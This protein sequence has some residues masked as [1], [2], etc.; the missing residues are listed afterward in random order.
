MKDIGSIFPL[1]DS[2]FVG[3][4]AETRITNVGNTI[5]YSLC[6]ETFVVIAKHLDGTNR[7]VLLPAYTCDTIITPF[8]EQGWD[9]YYYPVDHKL[10]I[11]I[12]AVLALCSKLD[13]DLMVVHP[14]YGMD[15]SQKEI[16][17]LREVHSKGCKLVVDLTQCIFSKQRLDFAD[18]YV[19]SYR[20]WF[21][22][23]DGA[24]LE[25]KT[26]SSIFVE[27]L[28]ENEGFVSFQMDAMYL[29]GLYFSSDNEEV[30]SIS[31]RLNKMANDM[32]DANV[33]PHKMA[34]VSH[35]L[36]QKEDVEKNQQRRLNNF[37][38]LFEQLKGIDSCQLLCDDMS[39]ISTAPLY[40]AI[41]VSGRS[42]LQ[43]EL[44]AQHIY[45]PVIWPVVY[46][47]VL[48]NDV[49]KDIY[50]T[51]LAIPID[52]RYDLNDMMKIV[53]IIKQYYHD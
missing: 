7:K 50:D 11:D 22:I 12:D 29:R 1:Y 39:R 15:L 34:M 49:V 13:F 23:P 10:K 14:Y 42:E 2:D 37:R 51:I 47:E 27:E 46:E 8:K 30:K 32:V 28:H 6:R 52:Q 35:Q 24:F 31:R 48:V 4:G 5:F 53:D 18:Y 36:L 38:F 17:L 45:A 9:C 44:A 40:F 33:Q 26:S 16:T 43:A 19:G 41:F 20:K 25:A 21:S 3:L